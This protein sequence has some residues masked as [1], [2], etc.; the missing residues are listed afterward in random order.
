MTI[1]SEVINTALP[2]H[3]ENLLQLSVQQRTETP[4]LGLFGGG[5]D[6]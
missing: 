4:C 1:C 5:C 2:M 6:A 3:L